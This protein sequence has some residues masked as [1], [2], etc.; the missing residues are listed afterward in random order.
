MFIKY[1]IKMSGVVFFI[2]LLV[3]AKSSVAPLPAIFLLL[4]NDVI[5]DEEP[6]A[7]SPLNDT[8]LTY[9]GNYTDGN[10][11]TCTSNIV[12]D[13]SDSPLDPVKQDCDSGRD[14][15][16]NDDA[17][18]RAGFS[19]T[20]LDALG[21]DL[22]S[23][24]SS[25]SCVRDMVTGAIWEVK[26]NDGGIHDR[27]NTYR[28]G[29]IT[30][31]SSDFGVYYSDWDV[32]VNGANTDQLCGLSSWR[33]PTIIELESLVDYSASAPTIDTNY[34]LNTRT[35]NSYYSATPIADRIGNARIVRFSESGGGISSLREGTRY[36]RL[37]ST[38]DDAQ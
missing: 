19:F 17:D 14:A 8:G 34:F 24:A 33:V 38:S 5:V 3:Y 9:G 1:L 25:W 15:T 30:S 20:K 37:I 10:E 23:N 11:L 26:T 22:R 2:P 16:H 32:L 31:Q 13:E 36:V 12:I 28:W 21:D 18:G 29:G 6:V 27:D 35:D 4:E 7:F